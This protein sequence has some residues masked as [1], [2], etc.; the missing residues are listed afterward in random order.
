MEALSC[1]KMSWLTS[2]KV[3][4]QL[5]RLC[6][7]SINQFYNTDT[8]SK[9][10][11]FFQFIIFSACVS[12]VVVQVEIGDGPP[13]LLVLIPVLDGQT[14]RSVGGSEVGHRGHDLGRPGDTEVRGRRRVRLTLTSGLFAAFDSFRRFPASGRS[15]GTVYGG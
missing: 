5:R 7:I 10:L 3:F 9:F 15:S 8:Q 13:K 1:F 14:R 2:D 11:E 6:S 12:H 4:L